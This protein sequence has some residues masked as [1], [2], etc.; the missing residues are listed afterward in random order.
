MEMPGVL[1]VGWMPAADGCEPPVAHMPI[2]D[3]DRAGEDV[4]SACR[5]MALG[6]LDDVELPPTSRTIVST[7]V[8]LLLPH[9]CAAMAVPFPGAASSPALTLANS[10]GLIDSGYRGEIKLPLSNPLADSHVSIDAGSPIVLLL[11]L[12]SPQRELLEIS[13][14]KMGPDPSH[15]ENASVP[16]PGIPSTDP[17]APVLG[18][19]L[20]EPGARMPTYAHEGDNG[21]DLRIA[22]DS[23]VPPLGCAPASF[24]IRL[25]VPEGHVG[26]LIPRSGLAARSGLTVAGSP[27]PFFPNEEGSDLACTLVNLD[28]DKEVAISCGDRVAQLIVLRSPGV[29][30]VEVSSMDETDRGGGGFGSSGIS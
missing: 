18:I 29:E 20:T 30:L 8:R 13:G 22:H 1:R 27:V 28:P 23:V 19:S 17:D 7:G 3:A 21:L 15:A 24:G 9:G 26:F 4:G 2:G 10:P 16:V 14:G 12:G 25:F 5:A 6:C 11:V